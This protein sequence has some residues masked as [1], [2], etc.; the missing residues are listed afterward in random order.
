[1]AEFPTFKYSWP[2]PLIESHCIPSCITH[3]PLP[4]HQ[5]SLKPKKLF[6]NRQIDIWDPLYIK[7]KAGRGHYWEQFLV[8]R[9]RQLELNTGRHVSQMS[10]TWMVDKESE[11]PIAGCGRDPG[12]GDKVTCYELW[13]SAEPLCGERQ[14]RDNWLLLVTWKTT[15]KAQMVIVI[16]WRHL[17]TPDMYAVEW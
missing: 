17:R 3:R 10:S 2:W 7:F 4:T 9:P 5:I 8:V 15:N 12:L 13:T 14:A 16:I 1:M 11:W 6:V